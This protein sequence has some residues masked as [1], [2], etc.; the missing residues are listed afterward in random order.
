MKPAKK[1]EV[2]ILFKKSFPCISTYEKL[3]VAGVASKLNSATGTPRSANCG[4]NI[5]AG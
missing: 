5:A 3:S 1:Y 4:A 2:E